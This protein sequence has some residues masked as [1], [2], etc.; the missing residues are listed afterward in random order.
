MIRI[1]QRGTKRTSECKY[2]GCKFSFDNEDIQV[3]DVP[4]QEYDELLYCPQCGKKISVK[5]KLEDR[6]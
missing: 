1:I 2:C 5:K 6:R 4:C 3:I